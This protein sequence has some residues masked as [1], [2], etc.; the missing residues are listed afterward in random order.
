VVR[1]HSAELE[2]QRVQQEIPG[3]TV[4]VTAHGGDRLSELIG[5]D[6]YSYILASIY[7]SARTRPS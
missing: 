3:V 7:V 6:S 4:E 1:H 5:Q 2:I